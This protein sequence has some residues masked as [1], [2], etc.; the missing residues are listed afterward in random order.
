MVSSSFL[1]F[2]MEPR[3]AAPTPPRGIRGLCSPKM[4]PRDPQEV[5]KICLHG[6]P[7][8]PKRPT[9]KPP[10]DIPETPKSILQEAYGRL[11]ALLLLLLICRFLL[12]IS[13]PPFLPPS[14]AHA[15]PD[16]FNSH[17]HRFWM[18]WWRGY[19]KRQPLP[20]LVASWPRGWGK[21][22]HIEAFGHHHN[23]HHRRQPGACRNDGVVFT[24]GFQ[25]KP[26]SSTNNKKK[27][28]G[29]LQAFMIIRD[30]WV[31]GATELK[32]T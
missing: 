21:V 13:H 11:H 4:A 14:P 26:E 22:Y 18:S 5:L 7:R 27:L 17:G 3:R 10:R 20:K 15:P 9:R 31:R 25:R 23:H 24:N 16:H 28:Y 1:S 12:C 30:G 29:A 19:A 32:T 2:P 8:R 6:P